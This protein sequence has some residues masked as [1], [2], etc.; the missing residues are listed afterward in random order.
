MTT[1]PT[2]PSTFSVVRVER[3]T[4]R[5]MM[6]SLYLAPGIQD[7]TPDEEGLFAEVESIR[8]GRTHRFELS[9][10]VG[11]EFWGI[12]AHWIGSYP[13]HSNGFGARYLIVDKVGPTLAAQL[14]EAVER[15]GLAGL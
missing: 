11:E 14:T 8:D 15:A 12:D 7:G 2:A 13:V 10:M 4:K 6:P 5:G 1:S 3:R 9:Q